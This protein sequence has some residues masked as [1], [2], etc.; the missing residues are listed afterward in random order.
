MNS[1]KLQIYKR[2]LRNLIKYR[3]RQ[4]SIKYSKEKGREKGKHTSD[5]ETSLRICEDKWNESPTFE[6]Q[7][8][9]EKLKVEYDSIYEQIARGVKI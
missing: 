1:R 5:I 7:E 8:G 3:I 2:Q 4:V 6:N 9:I